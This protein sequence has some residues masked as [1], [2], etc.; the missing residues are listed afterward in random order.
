MQHYQAIDYLGNTL[1]FDFKKMND[2]KNDK[3]M[4]AQMMLVLRFLEN[5]VSKNRERNIAKHENHHVA[6][7]VDEAHVFIDERSPAALYFM[8]QM[9][10]FHIYST[11][12][13][14]TSLVV[15]TRTFIVL[16]LYSKSISV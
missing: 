11:Q 6:I 10:T 5:E 1:L 8:H 2:S 15:K 9:V 12:F 14:S 13:Y 3:V 4:N 16:K 7:V